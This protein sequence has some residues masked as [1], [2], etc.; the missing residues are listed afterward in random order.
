[1][2]AT[3]STSNTVT[4]LTP[5]AGR[6]EIVIETPDTIIFSDT[7]TLTLTDHG[8][9]ETGILT[10]D[11]YVQTTSN[12]VIA[13]EEPTTAVSAGVLTITLPTGKE[14]GSKRIYRILGQSN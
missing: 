13:V 2:V 7:I 3:Y 14:V 8:I 4:E 9:S 12:S 6:K 5:N 11:G 10:I 1:M